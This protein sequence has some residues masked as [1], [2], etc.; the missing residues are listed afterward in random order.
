VT[1]SPKF[2]AGSTYTSCS[3]GAGNACS[4]APARKLTFDNPA[5]I[6]EM[7]ERGGALKDLAARQRW[8]IPRGGE[9]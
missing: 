5:K 7:A 2:G 8:T 9:A 1:V 4:S 6:V 3:T